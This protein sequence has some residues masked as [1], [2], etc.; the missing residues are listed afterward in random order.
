MDS[1]SDSPAPV[2]PGF[3]LWRRRRFRPTLWKSRCRGRRIPP[4]ARMTSHSR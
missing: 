3:R 4:G 2:L 1:G